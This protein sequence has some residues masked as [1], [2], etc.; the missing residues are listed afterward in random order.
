MPP[1]RVAQ[2]SDKGPRRYFAP[3]AVSVAGPTVFSAYVF[4]VWSLAADIGLTHSFPWSAG[5][6]SSWFIWLAV[7]LLLTLATSTL[8]S[9]KPNRGAGTRTD[10]ARI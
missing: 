6:L 9:N 7:A 1:H 5:P 3:I 10:N 4:A 2:T 8:P